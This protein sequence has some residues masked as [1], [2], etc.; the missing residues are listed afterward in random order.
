MEDEKDT[1][2]DVLVRTITDDDDDDD[3]DVVLVDSS[4][5]ELVTVS[6]VTKGSLEEARSDEAV[7]CVVLVVDSLKLDVER[8]EDE[9]IKV[10]ID[11]DELSAVVVVD[12]EE[13]VR[14]VGVVV[15]LIDAAAM[16][17]KPVS[18]CSSSSPPVRGELC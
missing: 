14:D 1:E 7:V 15:E 3:D 2:D 5:L 10:A 13:D 4:V 18:R 11:E 16:C 9:D 6:L 8:E 17:Y 12:T